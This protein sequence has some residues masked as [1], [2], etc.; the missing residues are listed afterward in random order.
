VVFPFFA[1]L[2]AG[3]RGWWPVI[4]PLAGAIIAVLTASRATVGLIGLGLAVVF[5]LSAV[6]RWTAQK[7]RV[8]LFGAIAIAVLA[9]LALSSLDKRFA[10]APLS[11]YDE[12]AA[13]VSA[14]AMMLADRPMGV[15]ANNFAVVNN[16]QAYSDRAEIAWT[17]RAAIVHNIYWLTLAEM[18]YL[19]LVA[20]V[21]LLLGPLAVALRC[22]WRNRGDQRG[23]LMIGF[24]TTLLIIYV[25]SYFEW[26]LFTVQLQY[27]FAMTAGMIAGLAQEMGYWR[28]AKV[29]GIGLTTA[30]A[31]GRIGK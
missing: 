28:R 21:L 31:I 10:A 13:L 7:A 16:T 6:R 20:L 30:S 17:S 19:G 24:A 2:L 9:P 23:D 15:G 27:M 8:A 29:G 3:E 11:D 12:R 5:V 22:G 25:H 26:V 1:L 18:G 4:T 14:S